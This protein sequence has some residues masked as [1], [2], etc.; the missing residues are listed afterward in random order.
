MKYFGDVEIINGKVLNLTL[1]NLDN[2]P[3]DL[4]AGRVYFNASSKTLK[5]SNGTEFVDISI[6]SNFNNLVDTL[7]NWITSDYTFDPTPFNNLSQITGLTS[8]DSLFTVLEKFNSA[9]EQIEVSIDNISNIQTTSVQEGEVLIFNGV[10]YSFTTIDSIIQNYSNVKMG[11]LKDVEVT[12]VSN[13]QILI[14]DDVSDTYKAKTLI[15][16]FEDLQSTQSH[17]ITH[18][19]GVQYCT[20]TLINA[21]NNTLINDATIN[22]SNVNEITIT[23]NSPAPIKGFIVAIPA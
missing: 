13:G 18:D 1:E 21:A 16:P 15:E 7:G 12:D 5:L 4:T 8:N 17:V 22:F 9:I 10:E 19:M 14:Y 3:D 23:L 2:D 20:V 11:S 6:P